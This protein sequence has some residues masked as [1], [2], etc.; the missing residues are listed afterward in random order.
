M[1]HRVKYRVFIHS[2]GT[3]NNHNNDNYML[4]GLFVDPGMTSSLSELH[5]VLG[6]NLTTAFESAPSRLV[7]SPTSQIHACSWSCQR[8]GQLLI[9]YPPGRS[10]RLFLFFCI[11]RETGWEMLKNQSAMWLQTC[12][13]LA[14]ASQSSS[15]LTQRRWERERSGA[16][17]MGNFRGRFR[18]TN[19]YPSL[20]VPLK[21]LL[22]VSFMVQFSK[23]KF[24]LLRSTYD[25]Q[26][27]YK[28]CLSQPKSLNFHTAMGC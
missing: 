27:I 28:L 18:N 6:I 7:S 12:G 25:C 16:N 9:C 5:F 24:Q 20:Q 11:W 10:A 14:A 21:G 2:L 8:A 22:N 3:E 17:R 4:V 19:P 1:D 26:I 23:F 13:S 15:F